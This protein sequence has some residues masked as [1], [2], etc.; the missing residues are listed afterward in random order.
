MIT[1]SKQS[2]QIK[3][4]PI[5]LKEKYQLLVKKLRN[6]F[7]SIFYGNK[8]AVAACVHKTQTA[9]TATTTLLFYL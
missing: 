7:R 3:K 9:A 5:K 6:R 4:Y 8:I 2:G 1:I